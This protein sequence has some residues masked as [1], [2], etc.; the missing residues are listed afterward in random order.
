M[1]QA[2]QFNLSSVLFCPYYAIAHFK[3]I[4]LILRIREEFMEWY[5]IPVLASLSVWVRRDDKKI[6]PWEIPSDSA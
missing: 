2:W 3:W 5:W 4:D 6:N 1:P